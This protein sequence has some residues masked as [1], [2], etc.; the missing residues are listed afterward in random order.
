MGLKVAT[1]YL[2]LDLLEE[3]PTAGLLLWRPLVAPPA[4]QAEASG[5]VCGFGRT[6]LS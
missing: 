1:H 2:R 3:Q 4:G 6:L 5:P